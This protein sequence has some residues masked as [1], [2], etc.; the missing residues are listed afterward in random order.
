MT[1]EKQEK[2]KPQKTADEKPAGV[3]VKASPLFLQCRF[4]ALPAGMV[5]K[6]DF[7]A[8]KGGGTCEVRA[9]TLGKYEKFFIEVK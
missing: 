6:A 2:E 4:V 8:L 1:E 5:S 3:S 9:E 7:R